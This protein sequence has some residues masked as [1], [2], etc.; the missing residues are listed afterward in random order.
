MKD[1]TVIDDGNQREG[2]RTD[3]SE[4]EKTDGEESAL[5]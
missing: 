3:L 1:L 4:L 2:D 5:S